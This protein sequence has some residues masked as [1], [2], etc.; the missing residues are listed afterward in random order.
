M[1]DST[2]KIYYVYPPP[3]YVKSLMKGRINLNKKNSST[4]TIIK[5]TIVSFGYV[6]VHPFENGNGRIL[7]FLIHDILVRDDIVP[8]STILPTSTKIL[9]NIDEHDD[10]LE[11]VCKLHR[12]KSKI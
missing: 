9:V 3:Q 12:A 1:K 11:L 7:P 6:Y 8:N 10:T 2:N 5:A 4:A